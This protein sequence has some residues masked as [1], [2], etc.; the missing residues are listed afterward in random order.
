M[1]PSRLGDEGNIAVPFSPDL[2]LIPADDTLCPCTELSAFY[3]HFH[4]LNYDVVDGTIVED[5]PV[6]YAMKASDPDTM[7]WRIARHQ[8]DF[9][10]F[11]AAA[12]KEFNELHSKDTWTIVPEG[13]VPDGVSVLPSTMVA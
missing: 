9:D 2:A 13:D 11:K 5:H 6:A 12:A 3:N 10:E 8:P 4:A 1:P 7:P